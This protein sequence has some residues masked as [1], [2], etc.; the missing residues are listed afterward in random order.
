MTRSRV[1]LLLGDPSG[2]GP[3][4]VAK[5]LAWRE[6]RDMADI[7]II[8]DPKI[9]QDA[10]AMARMPD[11]NPKFL[12]HT[13]QTGG[14]AAGKLSTEAGRYVLGSIRLV[15]ETFARG[16]IDAIVFAPF[17]KQAMRL[18]GL[19]HEDELH[20]FAQLLG[21]GGAASEINVC[22]SLWTSRVTS[23]VPFKEIA[24]LLDVD[25][26]YAATLTIHQ[27]LLRTG[28][29]VPRIAVAALNPH[30]G[31][32]GFLGKEEIEIIR[33]AIDKAKMDGIDAT[34][35]WPADTLFIAA[36]QGRFDGVVTMY[37]D[38]GQIALKLLGFD[39]GVTVLAGL[40]CIITT[41]AHGTAFDIAGTGAA[42][43]E[44]MKAAFT[45]ACR[46]AGENTRD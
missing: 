19:P 40:P 18:A 13:G 30:A 10:L 11:M 28:I 22:G 32:G 42:S 15:A 46:M 31:E 33:P 2:I 36:T 16:A 25:K 7:V 8:G 45:L 43:V 21:Q 44:P 41:P 17:N 1:G 39:R 9:Y 27:A 37:H 4:L 24:G 3:E 35:P 38:Q 12:L 34:G 6:C 5:L 14:Y 26:I 29:A 23:H 20:Y